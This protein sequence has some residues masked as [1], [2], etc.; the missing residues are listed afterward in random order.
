V[1]AT[2]TGVDATTIGALA[3]RQG[4]GTSSATLTVDNYRAFAVPEPGSM[5][6]LGVAGFALFRRRRSTVA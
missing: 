5:A 6:L 3:L 1:A 2:T 4:G